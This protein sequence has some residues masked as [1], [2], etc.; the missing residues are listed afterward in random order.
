MQSSSPLQHTLVN[1][2]VLAWLEEGLELVLEVVQDRSHLEEVVSPDLCVHHHIWVSKLEE[3]PDDLETVP[4]HHSAVVWCPQQ[5]V[6]D[7]VL[8]QI[9]LVDNTCRG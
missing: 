4:R 1:A 6:R 9:R 7:P 5:L 8:L 3:P 2:D